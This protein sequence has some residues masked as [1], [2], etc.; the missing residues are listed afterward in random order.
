MSV[1][2]PGRTDQKDAALKERARIVH[3]LKSVDGRDSLMVGQN[4]K[5]R[6]YT[7]YFGEWIW[8]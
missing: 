3:Q 8:I 6:S 5:F 1:E 2:G 7:R 4:V